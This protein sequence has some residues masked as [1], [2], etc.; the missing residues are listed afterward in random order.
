MQKHGFRTSVWVFMLLAGTI[1]ISADEF[2]SPNLRDVWT[3]DDP[4]KDDEWHLTEEPGWFRFKV[5]GLEDTWNGVRGDMPMLLQPSPTGDYSMETHV[6]IDEQNDSTYGCLVVWL[7]GNNWIHLELIRNDG[8][9]RDGAHAEHWPGGVR[10]AKV[11]LEPDEV[12]LRI[13]RQGDDWNLFYKLEEEEDWIFLDKVTLAID[14]PHQ[15]G[16]GAKTWGNADGPVVADFDYFRCPEL[17]EVQAVEPYSK[18]AATWAEVK[19][20]HE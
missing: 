20:D 12:Y 2:D 19:A 14:D 5:G 18:L 6:K 4:D 8:D 7:N 1:I 15:V 16:I 13:E 3:W 17:A 10:H 9:A 11:K